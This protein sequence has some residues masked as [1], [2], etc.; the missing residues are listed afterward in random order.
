MTA[1]IILQGIKLWLAARV[2]LFGDEAFYWQESR[3]LAFGYSDLPGMT[4]WLVRAGQAVGGDSV[5]GVRWPFLLLGAGLPWL[6]V[7]FARRHVDA[8]RAWQAGLLALALPLAGSLGVLAL[9]DVM[10]TVAAVLALLAL[11]AALARDRWRDWLLLGVALALAWMTHYRAAMLMLAGLAF[12]VATPRGRDA[13]RRPGLYLALALAVAGMLPL[14]IYNLGHGWAGLDFQAVQ[15]NPWRFHA[16]ALVQPLE[17]A[18]VCTPLLYVL[19]VWALCH[20]TA[21]ARRG[22]P[23]DLIASSAMTFM[24]GYF[25]FGLF[26]D[27]TH[28]RLHWP[29]PGYLPLLV[30][31]PLLAAEWWQRRS[32]RLAIR[33]A[34]AAAFA[35][36][37]AGQ[38]AV[39]AYLALAS[40]PARASLLA[41]TK[42]Y[43]KAFAPWGRVGALARQL[44]AQPPQSGDLLVADNF[45]L[46][47]ELDFAL[48]GARRVYSLDSPAN[49]KHGRAPQLAQ[50]RLDETALRQAHAG[51]TVLLVVAETEMRQD[52]RIP[53]LRS[54][55]SRFDSI[56]PLQRLEFAGGARRFAFYR[57]R[58]RAAPGPVDGDTC[59]VWL[60]AWAAQKR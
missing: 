27:D 5:L 6:V 4:A 45:R 41:G 22:A 58:L 28:F 23:W 15:R 11:D 33:I 50:W 17:Q 55:C 10:L 7:A 13:W 54:I 8:R 19:L 25:L 9:P 49:T 39:L 35:L 24:L 56:E 44:L 46:A 31:V 1:F 47:A 37:A 21:R 16:D 36:A 30:V 42:A 34:L 59:V 2:P 26:A 12:C 43:P 57:A 14:L 38:A 40:T 32:A 48:R 20:A 18:L 53:W 3:H 60:H 51:D 52:R 29:L